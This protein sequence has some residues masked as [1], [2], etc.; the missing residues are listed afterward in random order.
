MQNWFLL[1]LFMMSF[2]FGKSQVSS[3]KTTVPASMNI[4]TENKVACFKTHL[5]ELRFVSNSPKTQSNL[6]LQNEIF[7]EIYKN[8]ENYQ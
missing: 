7:C 8:T 1:F 5:W 2:Y 6:F 3:T 4:Y